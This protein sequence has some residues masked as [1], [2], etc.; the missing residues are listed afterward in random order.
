MSLSW[1]SGLAKLGIAKSDK[2]ALY[3]PNW[4]EYIY[5]YLAL[6]SLGAT[7]VPL[8]YMLTEEE[9]VSCLT[10]C[11]AKALIAKEKPIV[12]L[13]NLKEKVSSLGEIIVLEQVKT[14]FSN[15]NQVLASG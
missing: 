9:L 13:A 10:H 7:V 2:V 14:A 4:P 12:S 15:F 5:S 6:F 11:Q 8:D 3:L 1:P